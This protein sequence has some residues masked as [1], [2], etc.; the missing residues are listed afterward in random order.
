[1]ESRDQWSRF[2]SGSSKA[3]GNSLPGKDKKPM[4]FSM[5]F[6]ARTR[7]SQAI[8]FFFIAGVELFPVLHSVGAF[9]DCDHFARYAEFF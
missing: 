2:G 1:M 5:L 8:I 6:R 7:S 4:P 9:F 3:L